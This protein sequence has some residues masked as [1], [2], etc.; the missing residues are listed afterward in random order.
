MKIELIKKQLERI[1]N[2]PAWHGPSIVETLDKLTTNHANNSYQSSH[3]LIEIISHMTTWRNFVVE[4][5]KGNNDFEVSDEMN[6]PQS[7][8]LAD[9]I[10]KLKASQ[11]TLIESIARFP[12]ERLKE[13][14]SGREYSFLTML[15]GIVHHDLY[16]LGQ[17]ALLN[18]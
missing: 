5:L 3:T 7:N 17:I 12:E 15:Y 8:V 14:V 6:F 13:K 11:Q 10:A 16:H 18:R 2:G 1:F 9:A 4:R